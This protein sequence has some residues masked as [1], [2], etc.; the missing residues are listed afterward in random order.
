MVLV[1]A[2][3]GGAGG[4]HSRENTLE[5]YERAIAIG[6]DYIEFD[7]QRGPDGH[8]LVGHSIVG[9][10]ACID[11][12]SLDSALETLR[13][14][15][16]AHV[17]LKFA[18]GEIAAITDIVVA[19]G[20]D[21]VVVTTAEDESVPGIREWSHKYA[22]GLLVGLSSSVRGEGLQLRDRIEAWFPRRRL[23][24]SGANLVVAHRLWARWWLRSYARRRGLPLLVWTVN[25][26]DELKRW[27]K[28]PQCWMVTTDFPERAFA[29][30][31]QG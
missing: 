30:R 20:H 26:A 17:D 28:D 16:K 25:E 13:G 29:A 14:R 4:D 2:H 10:G 3:R 9:Q 12:V 1:S 18:G 5:A 19:L 23:R 6:C 7:V 22:P 24:R 8:F 27:M 15:T 21:N 31:S 11:G